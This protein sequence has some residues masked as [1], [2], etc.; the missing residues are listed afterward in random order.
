MNPGWWYVL[1]N[2]MRVKNSMPFALTYVQHKRFIYSHYFATQKPIL[3]PLLTRYIGELKIRR[4]LE[5]GR[6]GREAKRA[7]ENPVVRRNQLRPERH[8]PPPRLGDLG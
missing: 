6:C 3:P 7:D 1:R 4:I 2:P 8:P 5:I